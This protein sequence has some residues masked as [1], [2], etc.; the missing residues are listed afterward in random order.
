M[1][2]QEKANK[3]QQQQRKI[4]QL[5]PLALKQ[6]FLK[7]PVNLKTAFS[8]ETHLAQGQWLEMHVNM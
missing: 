5:R 6:K 3:T 4:N 2:A 7:I 1:T 8:V